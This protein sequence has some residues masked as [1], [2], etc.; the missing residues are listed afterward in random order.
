MKLH[1][2]PE[3][4]KQNKTQIVNRIYLFLK[5]PHE[6]AIMSVLLPDFPIKLR[7]KLKHYTHI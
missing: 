6:T 2:G 4:R 3:K 1:D 7:N 5:T